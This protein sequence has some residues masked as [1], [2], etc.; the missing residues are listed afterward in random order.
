M[1]TKGPRILR[2]IGKTAMLIA[3]GII[4]SATGVAT[5]HA[6]GLSA[7]FTLCGER[8]RVNCVADG[9]TFWFQR[10]KIRIADIDAT[11]LS[12]PRCAYEQEKGEAAKRRLLVLLNAGPFSY[13]RTAE[14]KIVTAANSGSWRGAGVRLD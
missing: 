5:A 4:I 11:E 14:T 6:D 3:A 1:N 10:Q 9:D 13:L 8:R 7:N 2:S 12:P